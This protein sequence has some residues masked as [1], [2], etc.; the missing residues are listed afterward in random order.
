MDK[1]IDKQIDK[2]TKT[3]TESPYTITTFC[4]GPKYT[5]ILPHWKKCIESTCPNAGL[6]VLTEIDLKLNMNK[7]AWWDVV[8]LYK[9]LEILKQTEKPVVHID[10][11]VIVKK[12]IMPLVQLDYDII[13]SSEIGRTR[14]LSE[15]FIRRLGF[16]ISSGF[17]VIKPSGKKFMKKILGL[18]GRFVNNSYSDSFNVMKYILEHD[19]SI[20]TVDSGSYKN[21][22]INI[23][24]I[25]ICLL[26]CDIIERE[27]LFDRGQYALHINVDN[28]GGYNEFAR[29]FTEPL[30]SL[31][32]TCRCRIKYMP[33]QS[34]CPHIITR[35]LGIS[36]EKQT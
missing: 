28:V 3:N 18:M 6:I 16:A 10:L 17:H 22:I 2:Q 8:R 25:R 29:Y 14:A 24:G 4:H 7:Y 9:N 19:H 33:E 26:D 31:P 30:E 1:L 13:F 34:E 35:R 20:E 36:T 12:D 32:T 23:D 5:P 21:K 11:D 15:E 27:P